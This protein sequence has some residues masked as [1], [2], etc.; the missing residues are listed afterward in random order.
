MV[1]F[2]L[3]NFP[4]FNLN[5]K[6]FNFFLISSENDY[7]RVWQWKF[8]FSLLIVTKYVCVPLNPPGTSW[9][10]NGQLYSGIEMF[11]YLNNSE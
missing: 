7:F 11:Q 3:P 8:S 10:F 9:V 1:I 6:D 5:L 2:V 4:I